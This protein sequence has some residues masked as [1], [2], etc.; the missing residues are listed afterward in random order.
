[1]RDQL[2][3][4][5]PCSGPG[6]GESG[7][8]H[9]HRLQAGAR[10]RDPHRRP[11]FPAGGHLRRQVDMINFIVFL[12][13]IIGI[14]GILSLSVSVQ[15]GTAGLINLATVAFFMIGAYAS[16]IVV[17]IFHMPIYVGFL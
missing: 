12:L 8:V 16:A 5:A 17:M 6:R 15:Y 4:G 7:G 14:Y 2:G 13:T 11:D 3:A 1:P 10:L 9:S